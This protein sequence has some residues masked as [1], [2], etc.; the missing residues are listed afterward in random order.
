M[1]HAPRFSIGQDVVTPKHGSG[2]VRWV[3]PAHRPKARTR[4]SIAVRGRSTGLVLDE[5]QIKPKV[6]GKTGP[7]VQ[8]RDCRNH[9]GF[10]VKNS[11][12]CLI[13]GSYR[14]VDRPRVCRFFTS[15]QPNQ[16][17]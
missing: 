3:Y 7:E 5:Q 1:N 12:R 14:M 6:A 8:C 11:V 15:L 16:G 10:V 2:V 13:S 9:P 17:G 4:Y